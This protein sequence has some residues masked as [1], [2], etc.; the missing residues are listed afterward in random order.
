MKGDRIRE[1]LFHGLLCVAALAM[2]GSG[3]P[4]ANSVDSRRAVSAAEP[5]QTGAVP[6][7][8]M[9]QE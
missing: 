8:L 5:S 3:M 1:G 7:R 9:P 6:G 2:A 4:S